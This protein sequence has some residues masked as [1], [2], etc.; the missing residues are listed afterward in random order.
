[1]FQIQQKSYLFQKNLNHV[2]ECDRS[3]IL[4]DQES[5]FRSLSHFTQ[6]SDIAFTAKCAGKLLG[7]EEANFL[8]GLETILFVILGRNLTNLHQKLD[9]DSIELG[10]IKDTGQFEARYHCHIC[11]FRSQL[12]I[13]CVYFYMVRFCKRQRDSENG[14]KN[15]LTQG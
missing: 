6:Q 13:Q 12:Y 2:S 11:N 14:T 5:L 3:L 10:D 7:S 15:S 8:I 9:R 1:M 4:L